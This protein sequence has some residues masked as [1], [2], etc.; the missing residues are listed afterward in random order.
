VIVRSPLP[1]G[2]WTWWAGAPVTTAERTAFD[3]ARR[4]PLVE[5]VVGVDAML[6]ATLVT[7][8]GLTGFAESRRCWPGLAQMRSV[9]LLSDAGAESP[10]ESRLRMTLVG[11]GLPI[12]VTQYVVRTSAGMFVAR[13]DL[14]Y[15]ERKVGIEYDGDR[16]RGRSVFHRDMRRLNALNACGWTVLRFGAPDIYRDPVRTVATVRA[17]LGG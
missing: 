13:L 4:L 16:H 3:L 10:Q 8:R 11:G 14:A 15:P 2:D 12:P 5:A 7:R 1:G 6:A 17:A 9:L